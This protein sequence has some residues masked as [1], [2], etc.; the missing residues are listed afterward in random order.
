KWITVF[1]ATGLVFSAIYSLRIMQK[2]FFGKKE[3]PVHLSDFKWKETLVM[4]LLVLP[5]IFFG[6]HPKPVMRSAEPVINEWEQK[7]VIHEQGSS[8]VTSNVTPDKS[9]QT[10]NYKKNNN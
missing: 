8:T 2:I 9:D 1:A 3:N 4:T 7:G 5:L 6:L 10:N